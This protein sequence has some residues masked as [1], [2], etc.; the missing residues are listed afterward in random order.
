[1]FP[2]LN[3][4]KR[5]TENFRNDA[6]IALNAGKAYRGLNGPSAFS[7]LLD[8]PYAAQID[9]MH[10]ILHGVFSDDFFKIVFG[11]KDCGILICSVSKNAVTETNLVI[12]RFVLSF[13]GFFLEMFTIGQKKSINEFY[14]HWKN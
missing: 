1:M 10:T 14:A 2:Q 8:F 5:T 3:A 9:Y 11:Y 6:E 12:R 4:E 13:I 7:H